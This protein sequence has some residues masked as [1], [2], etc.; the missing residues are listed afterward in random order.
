MILF[1][2]VSPLWVEHSVEATG[3]DLTFDPNLLFETETSEDEDDDE[4]EFDSDDG[5]CEESGLGMLARF[6]AN[7]IP[8][9]STP[10]SLLHE[11]KHRSRLST[12]GK[13]TTDTNELC[14]GVLHNIMNFFILV[15]QVHHLSI[16][17]RLCY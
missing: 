1:V 17:S 7:A 16:C 15:Q 11:G 14:A 9:S 5:G 2:D 13:S 4:E 12:L 8:V 6:A 3:Y 10:L